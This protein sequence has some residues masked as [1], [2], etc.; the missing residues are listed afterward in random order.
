LAGNQV[1]SLGSSGLV[2][3]APS[4]VITTIP[5]PTAEAPTIAVVAGQTISGI[6]P[7]G[8]SQ[9]VVEGQTLTIGGAVATLSGAQVVSLG[10]SGFVVQAPGGFVTTLSV[11]TPEPLSTIPTAGVLATSSTTA[12]YASTSLSPVVPVPAPSLSTTMPA[13]IGNS[14]PT[15]LTTTPVTST[16]L[17]GIIYT[18]FQGDGSR[19]AYFGFLSSMLGLVFGILYMLNN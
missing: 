2:I 16:G 8:S 12:S 3:Q 10:S 13:E 4:G 6:A 5:V 17:G 9:A 7:L 14:G 11:P 15:G 18:T 1:A 19:T